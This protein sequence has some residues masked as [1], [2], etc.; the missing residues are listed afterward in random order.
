MREGGREGGR[1]GWWRDDV[2]K[3]AAETNCR[4]EQ[5]NL[6]FSRHYKVGRI[7]TLLTNK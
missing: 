2:K 4:T 3:A 1:E 6:K 7:I 5:F